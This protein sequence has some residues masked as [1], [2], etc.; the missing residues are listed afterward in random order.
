MMNSSSKFEWVIGLHGYRE[1]MPPSDTFAK[2]YATATGVFVR[3][4]VA[5]THMAAVGD[6]HSGKLVKA[7]SAAAKR[8]LDS[9][10]EGITVLSCVVSPEGSKEPA[11]D[12]VV[13]A[14][15]SWNLPNEL[16]LCVVVNDSLAAFL[17]SVF[18]VTLAEMLEIGNWSFGYAFRDS[19]DR[20]PDFH[21]LALDN[22]RLNNVESHALRM[23]YVS[24]P[25]ERIQKPRSIY[26][27]TILNE[28]QLSLKL[29][30]ATMAQIIEGTPG[31]TSNMVGDMLVWRVPEDLV[32][33]I[34]DSLRSA[35]ALIT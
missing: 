2:F 27:I 10:F 32:Q 26:P 5:M 35:G 3:M 16:L 8:V 23:W 18:E 34:R 22:G 31:T 4:G 19:I 30:G 6:G 28:T 33:P 15:L 17:S 9:G 21:V 11:Y 29:N 1:S 13:S 12:R 7:R 25:A 24:K 14:S 20:Q